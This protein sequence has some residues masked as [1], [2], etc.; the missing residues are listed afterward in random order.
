MPRCQFSTA[1][2]ACCL[3]CATAP[4]CRS[5][6]RTGSPV[7]WVG[8]AIDDRTLTC[9]HTTRANL[10]LAAVQIH[11]LGK[12]Y[13]FAHGLIVHSMLTIRLPEFINVLSR[14]V[15]YILLFA[16]LQDRSKVDSNRGNNVLVP[17]TPTTNRAHVR[18]CSYRNRV[19]PSNMKI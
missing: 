8:H 18:L 3:Q 2:L 7:I 17:C 16:Y 12:A 4:L 14:Y 19:D 1:V 6:A 5:A 15:D 10:P 13:A 9:A 11:S